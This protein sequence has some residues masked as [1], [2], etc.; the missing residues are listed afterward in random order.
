M[1]DKGV[2]FRTA[3]GE[4]LCGSLFFDAHVEFREMEGPGPGKTERLCFIILMLLFLSD[5]G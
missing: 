5:T 2:C 1:H 3:L 4:S